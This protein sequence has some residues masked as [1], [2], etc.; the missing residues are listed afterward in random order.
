MVIAIF[1]RPKGDTGNGDALDLEAGCIVLRAEQLASAEHRSK[2][3]GRLF[4]NAKGDF[5]HG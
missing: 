2:Q 1:S 3:G 4:N 5:Q